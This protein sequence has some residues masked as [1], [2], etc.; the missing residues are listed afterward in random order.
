[1]RLLI[2][3]FL[4]ALVSGPAVCQNVTGRVLSQMCKDDPRGT[5]MYVAGVADAISVASRLT[6]TKEFSIC[7]PSRVT[8]VDMVNLTCAKVSGTPLQDLDGAAF[9]WDALM[10]GWPCR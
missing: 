10:T 1:M 5:F 2:A 3:I 4:T 8:V 9:V 6:G 7:V